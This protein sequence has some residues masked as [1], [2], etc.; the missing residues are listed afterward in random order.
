MKNWVKSFWLVWITLMLAT[1]WTIGV[2]K[3]VLGCRPS[4]EFIYLVLIVSSVIGV[5][6]ALKSRE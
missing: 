4:R 1:Y 3:L 6:S 5:I 2:N